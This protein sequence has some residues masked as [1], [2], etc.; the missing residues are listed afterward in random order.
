[1]SVTDAGFDIT[2]FDKKFK[3]STDA[4]VRACMLVRLCVE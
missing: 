3:D 1:M 4:D 2:L